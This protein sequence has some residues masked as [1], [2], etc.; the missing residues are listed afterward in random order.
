MRAIRTLT[1]VLLCCVAPP[2][3]AQ[4]IFIDHDN[5]TAFSEYKTFQM[6]ETPKDLR[7]VSPKLHD[8][9][10]QKITEYLIEG[11]MSPVTSDPDVYITYYAA[12]IGD[13]RLGLSDLD[14]AYGKGFTPG[15][16]W[17]GGVGTRQVTKKEF[18]FKEG[19]VVVDVWDRERGI[20]VWR[21]MATS[22]LNRDYHKN[23]VKLAK[24]LDK[25]LKRWDKMYGGRARAIRKLKDDQG[26]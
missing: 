23:E 2:A 11:S 7:R 24:A 4:K 10:V 12:F 26:D 21:G 25:M 6:R 18:T 13:M 20:L 15:S 19:T 5:A 22:A 3:A 16:Y 14:Y 9:V 17:E 1:L 8:T